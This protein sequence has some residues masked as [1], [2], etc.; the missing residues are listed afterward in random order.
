M[1]VCCV[2]AGAGADAPC[3]VPPHDK[4]Q[5]ST[6]PKPRLEPILDPHPSTPKKRSQELLSG[7]RA[8]EVV[9]KVVQM[10]ALDRVSAHDLVTARLLLALMRESGHWGFRSAVPEYAPF[11][12]SLAGERVSSPCLHPVMF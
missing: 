6:S 9:R 7:Y 3:G 5:G 12:Y 8:D 1:C 2:G 10:L 4:P 11:A